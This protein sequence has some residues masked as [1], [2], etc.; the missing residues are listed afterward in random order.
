MVSYLVSVTPGES[1]GTMTMD[2]CLC[3]AAPTS[4]FPMKMDT[5]VLWSMAPVDHHLR[6][7]MT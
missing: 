1:R 7:L 5:L 6:P 2:C 3:L 4:V